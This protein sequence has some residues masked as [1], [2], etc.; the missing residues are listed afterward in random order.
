MNESHSILFRSVDNVSQSAVTQQYRSPN[1]CVRSDAN[2]LLHLLQEAA[3]TSLDSALDNFLDGEGD[4]T[5][6]F[7]KFRDATVSNIRSSQY[8]SK[9]HK[10]KVLGYQ[11]LTNWLC[12]P[13]V[14]TDEDIRSWLSELKM[15]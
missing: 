9:L 14:D 7:K 12:L 6:F 1:D 13:D 5:S 4:L 11:H 15:D 3:V 10:L 8:P 2:A